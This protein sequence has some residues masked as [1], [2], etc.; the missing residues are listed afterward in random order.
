MLKQN[1]FAVPDGEIYPVMYLA[2]TML[3]GELLARARAMGLIEDQAPAVV[4]DAPAPAD[5]A[6]R[7]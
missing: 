3:S 2:G 1:W 6:R 7:K 4:D 5:K